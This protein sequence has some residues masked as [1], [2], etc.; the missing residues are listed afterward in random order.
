MNLKQTFLIAITLSFIA[1]GSWEYHV[2]SEGYIAVIDDNKAL[3]AENFSKVKKTS[4]NDVVFLGSSRVHFDIQLDDWEAE[5][6]VRPIMLANDGTTPTPVFLEIVNN[7]NFNGTIVVGIT[8]PLFF[9][10]NLPQLP[11]WERASVRIEH[12]HN[13]TYAEYLNY[14][15]SIP[16]EN[17]FA[18]LNSAEEDWNDDID[19]KTMLAQIKIGNRAANPMPP[20]YNFAKTDMNRNITMFEKTKQDTAF[21]NT[22]KK[23]WYFYG[24]G[25]PPAVKEPMIELYNEMI[26]KFEARGGKVIFLRCPSSGGFRYGENKGIPRADF[27]DE[28]IKQTNS[29]GYHFEDYPE[30]NK[31]ICPEDSHLYTPDAKQFTTDLA[32]IMMNDGVITNSKI[33]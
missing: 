6:G 28:F 15:I 19:L 29:V 18:F 16:L 2:R 21:A 22:I 5:T 13:G 20:F 27:Y 30:L 24:S 1:L 4:K 32:K 11:F 7:T 14:K 17:T 9:T 33:N 3:W 25:A 26:P 23:V 10:P 31:Y 8:P 12:Y